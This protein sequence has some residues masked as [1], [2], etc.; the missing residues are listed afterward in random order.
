MF[1]P[2]KTPQLP[3]ERFRSLKSERP[4]SKMAVLH[5][6]YPEISATLLV[7]HILTIRKMRENKLTF[8][9]AINSPE[10]ILAQRSR[11]HLVRRDL[12]RTTGTYTIRLS[13]E[14]G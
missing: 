5:G 12:V 13:P 1:Y 14:M 6:L 10:F 9:E 7:G 4:R 11:L 3:F 8:E 2:N